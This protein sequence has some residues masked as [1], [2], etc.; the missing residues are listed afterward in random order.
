MNINLN[1]YS[2]KRDMSTVLYISTH[3]VEGEILTEVFG[4]EAVR[5]VEEN[6]GIRSID[7]DA[8]VK[9]LLAKFSHDSIRAVFG[10]NAPTEMK[11]ALTRLAVVAPEK[12][13][14]SAKKSTAE[15]A[16]EEADQAQ[17]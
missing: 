11:N 3:T 12:K 14:K 16:G 7:V 4:P 9:R 5:L 1:L 10:G 2:V 6:E 8:E 17:A 13:P 15:G